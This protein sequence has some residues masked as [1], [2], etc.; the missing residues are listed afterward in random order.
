MPSN[1]RARVDAGWPQPQWNAAPNQNGAASDW[2][3]P[4]RAFH[5]EEQLDAVARLEW[6]DDLMFAAIDGDPVALD[7]AADAWTKSRNELGDTAL[8]ESRLQYIRRAQ[9]VWHSLRNLPN[10][11]PH[12]VFAAIEIISLL[13]AKTR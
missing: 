9:T 10:H 5:A 1:E 3:H 7:Y 8:E 4:H 12:K 13:A 6:L 2:P 11:P